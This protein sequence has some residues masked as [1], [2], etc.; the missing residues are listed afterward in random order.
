MASSHLGARGIALMLVSLAASGNARA[1]APVLCSGTSP[2]G[3][4]V[5]V[6]LDSPANGA[7]VTTA[8]PCDGRAEVEGA[9]TAISSNLAPIDLYLV[10][11]SSGSTARCV[12]FDLDDDMLLGADTSSG[13]TDLGDS[14]LAAELAAL[15]GLVASVDGLDARVALVEFSAVLPNPQPGEQG[16]IRLVQPLTGDLALVRAGLDAVLA[17][18]SRG[19][20][21]YAGAIDTVL[22][23][24]LAHG[25]RNRESLCFFLTD[26]KPTFPRYPYDST[27]GPDVQASLDA[28]RRAA[29]AGLAVNTFEVGSFDD[30]GILAQ[31]AAITGGRAVAALDA[32]TLLQIIPQTQLTGIEAVVVVNDTTGQSYPA[33]L[34]ADGTFSASVPLAT[35]YNLLHVVVTPVGGTPFELA[36]STTIL[37]QCLEE[38]LCF[39]ETTDAILQELLSTVQ[40]LAAQVGATTS[41]EALRGDAGTGPCADAVREYL[42]FVLNVLDGR[43]TR[44]CSVELA[45]GRTV[46]V[47]EALAQVRAWIETGADAE[48]AQA[49]QLAGDVNSGAVVTQQQLPPPEP[50]ECVIRDPASGLDVTITITSPVLGDGAARAPCDGIVPVEGSAEVTGLSNLFDLFF[51]IDS[52]GSTSSASGRD[53]D[54][55]GFLGTGPAYANTD[56]GD[57]VLE[58]E[59]EAVR[60]FVAALDPAWARVSVIQFSNPEGF[61]GNGERQRLV[62]SLTDDFTLVNAALQQVSAGG[63]AGATDYGGALALLETEY[64]AN[65]DPANRIPI[66]F[67]LSD[68]IPTYPEPPFDETQPPDR[69]AAIDGATRAAGHGIEINTYEVGPAGADVILTEMSNITG[70]EFFA[71][72]VP[73]DIIDLLNQFSLVGI[74]EVLIE[75]ITTGS[76][77]TGLVFDD[78]TFTGTIGLEP[79]TNEIRITITTDT[80][81]PV[82]AS[83]NTAVELV[84]Y[85]LLCSP[86]NSATW[87]GECAH[88]VEPEARIGRVT[89]D[90]GSSGIALSF[91]PVLI[92]DGHRVYRGDLSLLHR[93]VYSHVSPFTGDPGTPE[94]LLPQG[95][96]SFVDRGALHDGRDWYYLVVAIAGANE[97]SF[98]R[99]DSDADGIGDAE[100]PA[101][102]DDPADLVTSACP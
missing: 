102:A 31:I 68:G 14:V 92:A 95:V 6:R 4:S 15:R 72:L 12:G 54:G 37:H 3:I 26:G 71:A 8:P 21:D 43:L 100:R 83:C 73:G 56:P 94:C 93:G 99:S 57:S 89:A 74:G 38:D 28:A 48:C 58:A 30:R 22:A 84:Y 85:N 10:V 90:P 1:Q 50:V 65:A 40:D 101:P 47:D 19:A 49:A 5:T 60:E 17:A 81:D 52:S 16:R 34:R 13:C 67:F 53:I 66:C 77:A 79:G 76:A 64:L 35:D 27:E 2:E 23:E 91:D 75:N 39:R 96:T 18:G 55:D 9:A 51:V 36:C 25:D 24:V 78:G 88:P 69:Q 45:P 82:T 7:I 63:S 80:R 97:S 86:L 62:Q 46:T 61:F 11:D 29:A 33:D 32:R 70:G 44:H 87:A 42:A 41:C 98:G 59:L 20:T